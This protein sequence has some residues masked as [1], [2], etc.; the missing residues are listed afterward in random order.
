MEKFT[1]LDDFPFWTTYL[2]AIL[3]AG[4]FLSALALLIRSL[5]AAQ[6]KVRATRDIARRR[7]QA[8]FF[9][10]AGALALWFLGSSMYFRF[11]AVAFGAE[12]IELIFFWPRPPAVVA[13][14][15]LVELKVVPA[16]RSCGH[17]E[18]TTPHERFLSV[19]FR[20]CKSAEEILKEVS[21]HPTKHS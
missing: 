14:G 19:T 16:P 7:R 18:V 2:L 17:M 13:I 5:R 4:G 11:H 6:H 15:D 10:I 3:V 12:Q 1:I 8:W 9:V 21:L 20:N